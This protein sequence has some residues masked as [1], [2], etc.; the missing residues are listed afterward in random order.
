MVGK[1]LGT[2]GKF[3]SEAESRN[4]TASRRALYARRP[5][6]IGE[7]I[8]AEM[9]YA[10]RPAI[11]ISPS[12]MQDVVGKHAVTAIEANAPVQWELLG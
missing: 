7:T 2:R 8:D 12:E 1:I 5:I 3:A 11:G 10:L 6:G 9:L 4:K